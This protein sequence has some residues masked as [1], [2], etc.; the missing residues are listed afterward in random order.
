M[1]S[2]FFHHHHH[3]QQL[4]Q[5]QNV[6]GISERR[7]SAGSP[8]SP[9]I[10]SLR[11]RKRVEYFEDTSEGSDGRTSSDEYEAPS[12]LQLVN[13]PPI[14][15]DNNNNSNNPLH[16]DNHNKSR[17]NSTFSSVKKKITSTFQRRHSVAMH[18]PSQNTNKPPPLRRS[19]TVDH[20]VQRTQRQASFDD[21]NPAM[22]QQKR[23]ISLRRT[24]TMAA[25]RLNE[26]KQQIETGSNPMLN[27]ILHQKSQF[28]LESS[29]STPNIC[30]QQS[31]PS[32]TF[33]IHLLGATS[34]GKTGKKHFSNTI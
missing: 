15:P 16:N 26:Q 23:K 10:G 29:S 7:F 25:Y 24:A 27:R 12:P 9:R 13:K 14:A 21:A 3:H 1:S 33:T 5:Q 18:T 2:T 22:N 30:R 20:S 6:Y 11:R 8:R 17:K 31:N 19:S 4:Q 34:V 28:Q 32:K